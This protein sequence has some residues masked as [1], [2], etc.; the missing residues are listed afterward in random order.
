M[1]GLIAGQEDTDLG[2]IAARLR[3]DEVSLRL[4]IDTLAPYPTVDV[5]AAVVSAYGVDPTWLITGDYNPSTHRSAESQPERMIEGMRHLL[6][7]P[8]ITPV[9]AAPTLG[10]VKDA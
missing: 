9:P 8:R 2:A 7:V 5:L 6:D 10:M 3:V 1:R 4:S